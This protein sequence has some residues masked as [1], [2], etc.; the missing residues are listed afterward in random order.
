MFFFASLG[1]RVGLCGLQMCRL[2]V[3]IE[4]THV[5][6]IFRR[7]REYSVFQIFCALGKIKTQKGRQ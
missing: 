4:F 2:R 5:T 6:I 1:L 3:G 7:V